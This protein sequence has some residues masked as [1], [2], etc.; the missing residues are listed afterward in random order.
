MGRLTSLTAWTAGGT[1]ELL[2]GHRIFYRQDGPVDGRAV[3]L[4]HGYPTSSHDWEPVLPALVRAGLRVTTVDFLGFGASDKPA[5]HAFRIAE[6]A[7]IVEAL[8]THL[9]ITDT[10]LVAHD[11]GVTVAQELL[12]RNSTRITAMAWLNGGLYPDLYRPLPIQRL[13][14]SPI[15]SLL[16]RATTETSYRISLRKTLGRKISEEDLHEMW[17]AT[18]GNGGRAVQRPLMAYIG[19]RKVNASRWQAALEAYPGPTLFVW[20]PADPISGGHVL[21]RLRERLPQAKFVV[22]EDDP[23]TGHYPHVENPD[24]V[25]AAIAAFF[26]GPEDHSSS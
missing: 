20:G 16:A 15:G 25:S 21:P 9:G 23:A 1:R 4:L 10:A 22:L 8:W 24:A 26:S 19:E 17:L 3:T 14:L 12:V 13:L 11:Y 5:G 6:Q 7:D 18:S 2:A